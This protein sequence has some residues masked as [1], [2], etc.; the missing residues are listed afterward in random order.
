MYKLTSSSSVIRNDG[1]VIPTDPANTDYQAYLAWLEEGN[2]PEP[3][4]LPEKVYPLF[5]GNEKL[6]IFTLEEQL[7][8]VTATMTDPMVKLMY[9]R[10]IGSAYLS[11]E[12]PETDQGLTLLVEKGLLT[13][14]RKNII[15]EIM[16]PK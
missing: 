2:A 15:V 14:E 11:Y 1:A 16:Q 10:M 5:R 12:D 6:D 3:A 9:D 8:V 7:A 4:D 13:Q